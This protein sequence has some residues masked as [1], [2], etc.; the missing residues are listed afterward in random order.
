M[1]EVGLAPQAVTGATQGGVRRRGLIGAAVDP[2]LVVP[3]GSLLL[4]GLYYGAAQ[5]GYALNF[6]GPVAAIVWLP[7]GVGIAFLYVAGMRFW[8]GVVLGD[9]LANAYSTI[10]L[11]S[12]IGQTIG[13]VLEVVLAV[14]LMR[15]LIGDGSP[16][17]DIGNLARMLV[18]ICAGT[19]VSATIGLLSLRLGG[20]V[21]SADLPKLWRT[22]WLGD[23]SGALIVV[24]LAVAWWPLPPREW[25]RGHVAEAVILFAAI[26]GLSELSLRTGRPL[27]YVVF[28]ALIWAALRFG[29]R[30]ATLAVTVAAG[31]AVWGTTHYMGPFV[32]GS[33]THS[34]LATQLY[35]AVAALTC[36]SLAAA[37]SEREEF[38]GRLRAS[39]TRL[40][41]AADDER[42]R[43]EHN[44]HDGAQQ[45][46]TALAVR[47]GVSAEEAESRPDTAQAALESAQ[48]EVLVAID[49]LR[50]LAHGIHPSVLTRFGL[51]RATAELAGRSTVP[52]QLD[53][54][55]TIRLDDIAEATAYY[56]F[57]EA[58]T[59][60]QKHAH[61]T[62]IEVRGRLMPGGLRVEVIDNGVGGAEETHGVGLQGLRDRVEAMGG[63]LIVESPFGGGTR[64]TAT[65]PATAVGS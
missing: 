14:Y 44:L 31:Y 45:R 62:S 17:G 64:V 16:L 65:I 20:V 2:R 18:A 63:V 60:A 23:M 50:D 41:E 49:E 13:N 21:S 35:L 52:T 6:S 33:I 8:P 55:P 51:A 53:G 25:W 57:A 30:G 22:W 19:A 27:A 42:R 1:P 34:I 7:V 36:L 48:R 9:M 26:M 4:A 10:P 15:R 59:N 43:L 39:R 11:G 12:A 61:A 28:P 32:F 47:L 5:L 3:L 24:P 58:M 40:V 37:V 38:A 56:V 54:L 29:T 46:L